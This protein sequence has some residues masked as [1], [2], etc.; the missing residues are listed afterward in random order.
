MNAPT[1]ARRTPSGW[2]VRSGDITE[3]TATAILFG[4]PWLPLPFTPAATPEQ[5]HAAVVEMTTKGCNGRAPYGAG[6]PVVVEGWTGSDLRDFAPQSIDLPLFA[7]V[8]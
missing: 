2:E 6:C 4:T 1:E 5:V 7:S 8:R 3:R